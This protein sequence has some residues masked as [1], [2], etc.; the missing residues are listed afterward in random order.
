MQILRK[1]LFSYVLGGLMLLSAGGPAQA[2]EIRVSAQ[3]DT[4]T[5]ALGDQTTLR[6]R[7]EIPAGTDVRFPQLADTLSAKVPI[8]EAGTT[9]TVQ[10]GPGQQ[11]VTQ[12]YLITSFDAG[13]QVIPEFEI[14]VGD[15]AYRTEALPLQVQAVAVDTTKAIY[16]IK[17][18]LE[19]SYSWLDW[20]RDNLLWVALAVVVLVAAGVGWF[21]LKKRKKA[22]APPPAETLPDIPPH[23]LALGKLQALRDRKLWQQGAV[24][25]Y[26]SE[27][28]DI[29]RDFLERRYRIPAME[30]TT[31][32]IFVALAATDLPDG[33]KTRLRQVLTLADLVKFAR[34]QPLHTDNEQSMEQAIAFVKEGAV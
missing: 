9:D 19:V 24:K 12:T 29:L 28:S 13:M 8:V 25:P 4:S 3:L 33:Q 26:H 15:S 14:T 17:Q 34:E 1:Q 21:V 32:E 6:L 18:P 23:E 2:Q 27:L 11:S 22:P 31:D 16:D 5:I 20:L 7:A 30:Q 10:T